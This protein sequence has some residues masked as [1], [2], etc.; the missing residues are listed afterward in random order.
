MT[1]LFLLLLIFQLYIYEKC[2]ITFFG[3][4]LTLPF[5]F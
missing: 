4:S 2:F 1:L 5:V 3:N